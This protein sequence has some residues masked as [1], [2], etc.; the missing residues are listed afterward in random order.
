M[1]AATGFFGFGNPDDENDGGDYH[2]PDRCPGLPL[3]VHRVGF[4]IAQEFA[5]LEDCE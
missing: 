5:D 1:A 3:D 4:L 2:D